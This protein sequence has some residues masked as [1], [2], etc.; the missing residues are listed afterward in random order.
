V[1]VEEICKHG[2]RRQLQFLLTNLGPTKTQALVDDLLKLEQ[3]IN[4]ITSQA[5]RGDRLGLL[6]RTVYDL[7]MKEAHQIA[8]SKPRNVV[9]HLV[10]MLG[11][12]KVNRLVNGV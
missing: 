6:V 3:E 2:L 4:N 5:V 12:D 10:R 9:R 7:K 1:T 11:A 8:H